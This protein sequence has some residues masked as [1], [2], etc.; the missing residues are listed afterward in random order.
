LY[1]IIIYLRSLPHLTRLKIDQI[2]FDID[3]VPGFIEEIWSVSTL[4]H[5]SILDRD[6][7]SYLFMSDMMISLSLKHVCFM[8]SYFSI[9]Q[10]IR[11]LKCTPCLENLSIG[12]DQ[13]LI[14]HDDLY[15]DEDLR[16]ILPPIR[17]LKIKFIG[18]YDGLEYLFELMPH[19]HDLKLETINVNIDGYVMGRYDLELFIKF[20]N[21]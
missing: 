18:Y 17:I 15:M 13:N 4:A 10:L 19:L 20:K 7:P 16:S 5:L 8:E 12:I 2:H 9:D 14:S 21:L 1:K 6:F 11:L 3:E